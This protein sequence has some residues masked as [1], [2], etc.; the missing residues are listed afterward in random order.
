MMN[1]L[2]CQ[3]TDHE[4]GT[5]LKLR[6]QFTLA[7]VGEFNTHLAGI[8]GRKPPLIVIDMEELSMLSSAGIGALIK[9]QR[10]VRDFQ[11]ALRLAALQKDIESVIRA[12]RLDAVFTITPSLTEALRP[13]A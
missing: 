7:E 11:C 6:G 8:V 13:N 1:G 10:S 3:I 4:N 12:S 9:L 2:A 5:V